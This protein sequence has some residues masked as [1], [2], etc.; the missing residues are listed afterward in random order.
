MQGFG[1]DEQAIIDVLCERVVYQR[2]NISSTYSTVYGRVTQFN[3][4]YLAA[5]QFQSNTKVIDDAV[6]D[7][8]KKGFDQ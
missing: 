8:F 3:T 7:Y 1:T 6:C 5:C 2:T 4:P